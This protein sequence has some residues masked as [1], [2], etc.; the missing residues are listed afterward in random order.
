MGEGRQRR[1][2][3]WGMEMRNEMEH[4]SYFPSRRK[5]LGTL[6][7]CHSERWKTQ[8]GRKTKDMRNWCRE[9]ERGQGLLPWQ[10]VLSPGDSA[11]KIPEYPSSAPGKPTPTSPREHNTEGCDDE[12]SG[13]NI[14][15]MP[16]WGQFKMKALT[17]YIEH[18][19]KSIIWSIRSK[20]P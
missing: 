20:P 12:E 15:Q 19:C 4:F 17:A 13:I 16:V 11:T 2:R 8:V 6:P 18:Q 3:R 7:G 14:Y 1:R 9:A 5:N 10:A